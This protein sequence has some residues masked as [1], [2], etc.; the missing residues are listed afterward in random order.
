MRKTMILILLAVVLLPVSGFSEGKYAIFDS[1][2]H[3]LDFLQETEGF[4]P[5]AAK[6][7]EANVP[8]AVIFGMG[9]AKQ[10]DEHAPKA[11]TYYLSNDSRCYYYTG[12]DYIMM[13]DY[14]AQ[15]EEIQKRF[16]PF[17]CGINPN[18]L[19]AVNHLA[20]NWKPGAI[21]STESAR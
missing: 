13:Q 3:Y 15:P 21:L 19:Y 2:L 9:L 4:E 6:M 16:V 14:L 18:D 11:P 17:L 5:L 1:H 10:W 20:G 8:Y 12:T 7:D